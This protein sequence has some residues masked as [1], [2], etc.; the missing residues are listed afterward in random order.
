MLRNR[1]HAT[2]VADTHLHQARTLIGFLLSYLA[3]MG[4][5]ISSTVPF[6]SDRW[7]PVWQLPLVTGFVAASLIVTGC[8]W[9]NDHDGSH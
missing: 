6:L 9:P 2:A 3:L 7:S 4:L 1:L 8:F 5:I